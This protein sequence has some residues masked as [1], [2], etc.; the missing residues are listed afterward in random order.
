MPICL[1]LRTLFST[2]RLG[3]GGG[4]RLA[5]GLHGFAKQSGGGISIHSQPGQGT[6]VLMVAA[7]DH[8]RAKTDAGSDETALPHGKSELVPFVE[9]ELE[10][11]RRVV[12]QQ[13]ID[14]GYLVI[15]AE[16]AS[17]RWP[18]RQIVD[19]AIVVNDIITCRAASMATSW[20]WP[21]W[22][23]GRPCASC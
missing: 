5:I 6:T 12:R 10:M 7:A 23:A 8:S 13:L 21:Y 19:V 11:S 20:P 17:R 9:D 16:T 2:K 4:H 14:L 3:L 18:D 15:Q 1:R 22:T